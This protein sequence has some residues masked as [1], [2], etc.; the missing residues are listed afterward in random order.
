MLKDLPLALFPMHPCSLV[1]QTAGQVAKQ[2]DLTFRKGDGVV[3]PLPGWEKSGFSRV[4]LL[5][6]GG[7]CTDRVRWV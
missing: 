2:S 7:S 1:L 3:M 6:A 4:N 5:W